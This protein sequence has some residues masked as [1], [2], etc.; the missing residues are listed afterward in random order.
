MK[1]STII[2][3]SIC[4]LGFV[5]A[6]NLFAAPA[7]ADQAAARAA[8]SITNPG[9]FTQSVSGEALLPSGLYFGG[10]PAVAAVAASA[11]P[12]AVNAVVGTP[13]GTLT[14]LPSV[15]VSTGTSG[16]TTGKIDS[17]SLNAGLATAVSQVAGAGKLS[18]V[19]ADILDGTNTNAVGAGTNTAVKAVS[20]DDAAAIIKAAAGVDGLD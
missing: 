12:P 7:N 17:Q 19:V 9:S 2:K 16:T 4:L 14:V 1:L 13:A 6:G 20:I 18:D 3:G 5:G 15:T 8:T 10:A 11:G